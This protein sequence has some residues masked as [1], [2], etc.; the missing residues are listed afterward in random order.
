MINFCD[1]VSIRNANE[2]YVIFF[3]VFLC[4][5]V[6]VSLSCELV[7]FHQRIALVASLVFGYKHK[8]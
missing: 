4:S 5:L 2:L 6:K 8:V 1:E 3:V 7:S